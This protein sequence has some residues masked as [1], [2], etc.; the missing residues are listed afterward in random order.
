MFMFWQR[1]LEFMSSFPFPT[2][3]K[4]HLLISAGLPFLTGA[5]RQSFWGT[6]LPKTSLAWRPSIPS[7]VGL[8]WSRGLG[9][10]SVIGAQVC[11]AVWKILPFYPSSN[12]K[13]MTGEL[14]TSLDSYSPQ[15]QTKGNLLFQSRGHLS[16][17]VLFL[18][19]LSYRTHIGDFLSKECWG[20]PACLFVS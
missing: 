7:Q 20:F 1:N 11:A 15:P 18:I 14:E 4:N 12:C 5:F 9:G 17:R 10:S 6:G 19:Y 8:D 3:T 16:P 13:A 2:S